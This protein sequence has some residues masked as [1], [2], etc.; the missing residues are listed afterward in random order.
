M[1][2]LSLLPT[3]DPNLLAREIVEAAIGEELNKPIPSWVS[4]YL[5]KI[6]RKGGKKGGKVRA[7]RLSAAQRKAI[8]KKAAK[9]R[10]E[11]SSGT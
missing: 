3:I 5:A 8:A 1:L 10:W 7:S 4:E 6:G 2:R 9:A 11:K